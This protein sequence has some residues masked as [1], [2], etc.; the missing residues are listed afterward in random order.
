MKIPSSLRGHLPTVVV[1]L[2]LLAGASSASAALV[3]NT[4]D[5]VDNTYT[6]ALTADEMTTDTVFGNDVYERT[7][8]SL[9][10]QN[11]VICR[12][13]GTNGT[14]GITSYAIV[15]SKSVSG[16]YFTYLYDF[17]GA[18]YTV[19]SVQFTDRGA[20]IGAASTTVDITISIAWSTDNT[21]W[22]TLRDI[23]SV[24]GAFVAPSDSSYSPVIFTEPV[25]QVYY[26]VTYT[27]EDGSNFD[28]S[29]R[30]E[31]GRTSD[32]MTTPGFSASFALTQVPEPST[33][34]LFGGGVALLA[35]LLRK[36]R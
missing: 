20:Y 27:T 7:L 33:C 31:F 17:T 11:G 15:P 21:N 9:P 19:D 16:A 2:S 26:R 30:T 23:T 14:T 28:A 22:T 8:V 4:G 35:L 32:G 24:D 6:Y 12:N 3:I 10:D 25:S 34:T 1:G 36:R 13:V 29:N 5:I 18:G